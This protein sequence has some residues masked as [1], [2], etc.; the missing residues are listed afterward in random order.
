MHRR[1]VGLVV[2]GLAVLLV[3]VVAGLRPQLV[4]GAAQSTPIQR[5]PGVGDCVVNP[6]PAPKLGVVAVTA[7]SGG[8]VPVYPAQQIQ[9]CTGARYG[10]ITAV[11]A[12]PKPTVVTGDDADGRFLNDPNESNCFVAAQQYLGMTTPPT[13]S[14]WQGRI[15]QFSVALSRPSPGQQAAGQRWAACIVTLPPPDPASAPSRYGNSIRNAVHTGRYR[16]QLGSCI[17]NFDWDGG[18]A[19]CSQPHVLELMGW[20]DSGDHLVAGVQV[21]RSCQ[22]LV[23]QLTAM[24]D[25]TAGGDLSIQ[26]GVKEGNRVA[27]RPSQVPAHSRISCGVTTSGDRKLRGSLLALGQQPIPWV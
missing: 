10:E 14:F 27:I 23:H 9:P 8:T 20:G 19:M 5:P 11:I 21:E 3:A 1:R 4:T 22:Q 25:P 15:L 2:I 13:K 6:L 26:I 16:D 12:A 18:L 24:P 7:D 17:P